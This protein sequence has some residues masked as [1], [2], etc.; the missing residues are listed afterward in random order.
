LTLKASASKVDIRLAFGI[1]VVAS[2]SKVDI[3]LAFGI[4]VVTV[5]VVVGRFGYKNLKIR[6]VPLRGLGVVQYLCHNC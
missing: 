6:S 4:N 1:N 3:R 5:P 2:A